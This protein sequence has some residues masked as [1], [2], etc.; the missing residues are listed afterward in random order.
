MQVRKRAHQ[1]T[2][3]TSHLAFGKPFML[4]QVTVQRAVRDVFH[5]QMYSFRALEDLVQSHNVGM[6]DSLQ[7]ANLV[8]EPSAR[9]AI[10]QADLSRSVLTQTRVQSCVLSNTVA[11]AWATFTGSV[12]TAAG[13]GPAAWLRT[14]ALSSQGGV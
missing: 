8:L 10:P 7:H 6:A 11:L 13:F 4:G 9:R 12:H 2:Y 14:G 3:E 1:L 5:A